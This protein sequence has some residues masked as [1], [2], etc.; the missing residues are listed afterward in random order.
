[1]VLLLSQP[2]L[3]LPLTVQGNVFM[4]MLS[5]R[6]ASPIQCAIDLEAATVQPKS[7]SEQAHSHTFNEVLGSIVTSLAQFK[8]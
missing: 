1:M 2:T 5:P 6:Q 7:V 4:D 8:L 3:R